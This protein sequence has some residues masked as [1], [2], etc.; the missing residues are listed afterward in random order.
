MTVLT[1]TLNPCID[2]TCSVER[3]VPDRKLR[4]GEVR[5][6]PGGGG[7]NVAR[8]I[9]ELGGD[10]R[11]LWTSGG[12]VG[13]QL[14][15]LLDAE[16]LPQQAV[17]IQECIREN[18]IVSEASSEDQYRFGMPGPELSGGERAEWT[19]Q[20]EQLSPS[21]SYIVFSGS[22]PPGASPGWYAELLR[23]VQ[24]EAR[25]VVDTKAEALAKACEERVYLVKPNLNELEE[26]AGRELPGDDEIERAARR[27]VDKGGVEAVLVSFGRAGALL[28]DREGSE[29]YAAPTV[30]LRSKIGAGDSMV[31]GLL[32]ALEQ[33][34][35]LRESAAFGVAAGAAAVMTE[36]TVLCRRQ[37]AERL[38]ER[39]RKGP[40][41][42]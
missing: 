40:G 41:E 25:L 14:E 36:G 23:A 38:Y 26:I 31:G 20:L 39:M 12:R 1:V 34:R 6:Y 30:P 11:S 13:Q 33:G 29:H 16:A 32:V 24:G 5:L 37:D 17:R 42:R 2:K 21:P 22:L 27:L 10:A 3:V 18:L 19:K 35:S 9:R 7:L 8:A 4:A 28:V 15:E